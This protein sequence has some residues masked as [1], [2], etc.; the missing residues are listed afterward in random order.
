MVKNEREILEFSNKLKALGVIEQPTIKH[1]SEK[2]GM[3][4][5][6]TNSKMKELYESKFGK[7]SI[8]LNYN[9]LPITMAEISIKSIRP[10]ENNYIFEFLKKVKYVEDVVEVSGQDWTHIVSVKAP[11][12][13]ALTEVV[14]N[15]MTGIS[16]KH[17]KITTM[18]M[19][20]C[21]LDEETFFPDI[22][23]G[24]VDID[25]TDWKIISLLKSDAMMPLRK[26][27]KKV[28][29]QEPT[30]H[31]RI[32]LLKSRG[33]ITGYICSRNWDV[34]PANL[35]AIRTL[36]FIKQPINI[37]DLGLF[38]KGLLGN[39]NSTVAFVFSLFGEWDVIIGIKSNTFIALHNFINED[40]AK[41]EQV[42][43]LKSYTILNS[44]A[45]NIF[46]DFAE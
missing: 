6:K 5:K 19:H 15:I 43:D 46:D 29:L 40:I 32:S 44:Y 30:V 17:A 35:A 28:G 26:I 45:R 11:S 14:S 7:I 38:A 24:T 1:I 20:N 22:K 9:R 34:I 13:D 37:S 36:L 4:V 3:S 31:R 39:K 27:S 10:S 41:H 18:I 8:S 33:V 16:D 21:V 12:L 42:V 2:I 25:K 23:G